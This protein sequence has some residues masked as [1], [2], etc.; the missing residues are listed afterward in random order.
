[1]NLLIVGQD[2][3]PNKGGISTYTHELA[4]ALEEYCNVTVL[5]LG[6]LGA[7]AIDKHSSFQ[8]V[9]T[10]FIPL[11]KTAALLFYIPWI[12]RRY[13]I[14]AVLHTVWP[15]ALVSHLWHF[16][17]QVPY[18][19]SIHA[20]EILDDKRTWRRRVKGYLKRW[21][22]A[23]LRC[24]AAIFPVS[25]YGFNLAK[26]IGIAKSKIQVISNGVNPARFTPA[27]KSVK[28]V[29]DPKIILTVARLDLHKGHDLVLEALSILKEE[30][31]IP[32]YKIV[33]EGEQEQRLRSLSQQLGIDKQVSFTGYIHDSELPAVYADADLFIMPSREISGR[34]DLVEGFGISFLEASASG[35]PVIAGRSGGV[36]DAVCDGKT[37]LIVNPDNPHEIASAIKL[38]LTDKELAR[39]LGNEGRRWA[40]TEMNWDRVAGRL[41]ER[42]QLSM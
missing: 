25:N 8:I 24:A 6:A 30:D 28:T 21:R 5:A 12:I 11:L 39:K 27:K 20:S 16:A 40:V 2:F 4:H 14:D 3:P 13:H 26:K 41:Y 1:V 31:L 17:L 37:G 9:R 29:E 18:F 35:L 23:S 7:A 38:I 34:L 32:H 15:T 19:V 10:P 33:G 36:A 42:I 22:L